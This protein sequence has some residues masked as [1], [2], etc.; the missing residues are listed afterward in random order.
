[1]LGLIQSSGRFCRFVRLWTKIIHCQ[2]LLRIYIYV[3][4][5]FLLITC[6]AAGQEH[7]LG[8]GHVWAS[9]SGISLPVLRSRGLAVPKAFIEPKLHRSSYFHVPTFWIWPE[10]A[11][12][13][14]HHLPCP[15]YQRGTASTRRRLAKGHRRNCWVQWPAWDFRH[16]Q[17]APPTWQSRQGG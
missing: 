17:E 16:S 3:H 14:S 15:V 9:T 6:A 13:M 5:H 4:V 8:S 11:N 1:M 7:L 2:L 12:D 10:P